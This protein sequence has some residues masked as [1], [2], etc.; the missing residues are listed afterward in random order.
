MKLEY[1]ASGCS[2][3]RINYPWCKEQETIDLINKFFSE[4]NG[5]H[6]HQFSLLFNAFTEAHF[7]DMFKAY[8]PAIYKTH[9]DSGGLQIVTQGKSVT[10]EMKKEIYR[11]QAK[12]SDIGMSF[13]VIPL[14]TIGK[15]KRGDL[16]TRFFDRENLAAYAKETGQNLRDQIETFLEEKTSCLPFFIVHGND[17]STALEW[18]DVALKEVP[19]DMRQYIGG[20]AMGGGSFGNGRKEA[21]LR[22]V[23]AGHIM[24][25]RDDLV[26]KSIHFLGLGS[27]ANTFPFLAMNKSGLYKKD[28]HISYDSTS[29]TSGHHMGNYFYNTGKQMRMNKPFTHTYQIIYDDIRKNLKV[30]DEHADDYGVKKFH[31]TLTSPARGYVDDGGDFADILYSNLGCALSSILNFTRKVDAYSQDFNMFLEERIPKKEWNIY[32]QIAKVDSLEAYKKW[33]A[34]MGRYFPSMQITDY[35]GTSL[36]NFFE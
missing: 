3:L 28:W 36:D 12:Y 8:A 25:E 5:A 16:S 13:D 33:D 10:A 20:I 26:H 2:F 15:S 35:T 24:Q 29:H 7:G 32:M 1:V 23:L 14:I 31:K 21:L 11:T 4:V 17:S 30:F 27:L 9:A 34:Q 19:E 22:A 18:V 6:G